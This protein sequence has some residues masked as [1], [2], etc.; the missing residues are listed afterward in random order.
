VR[1]EVER[2]KSSVVDERFAGKLFVL[3]GKLESMTRDDAR[4][5]I[6]SKGGRVMSSVSRKTDF[7]V[8]GEEAG[9]KLDKAKELNV[10]VI[11]EATFGE[12]LK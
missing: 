10:T 2:K 7:V 9:S 12:M 1:T 8:A 6:E 3:T 4:A 11:D 5:M